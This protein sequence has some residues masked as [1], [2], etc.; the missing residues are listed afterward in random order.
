MRKRRRSAGQTPI[1]AALRSSS[2]L[3]ASVYDGI[4]A[5]ERGHRDILHD[6]IKRDFGDS[7]NLDDALQRAHPGSNRWDYLLGHEPSQ[8]LVGMEVHSAHTGEVSVLIAKKQDALDQLRGHL[9]DGQR[10]DRWLWVASGSVQILDLDKVRRKLDQHG[11]T[12]IGR[13]V[14]ARHLPASENAR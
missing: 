8:A 9:R 5:L 3:R 2:T 12:F 10:V 4:D 1:R 11:I 14:L 13:Q 7:L 6:Q